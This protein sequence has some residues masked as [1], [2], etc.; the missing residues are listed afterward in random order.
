[1]CRTSQVQKIFMVEVLEIPQAV[2]QQRAD[3]SATELGS[4]PWFHVSAQYAG[5]LSRPDIRDTVVLR[6]CSLWMNHPWETTPAFS[7]FWWPLAFPGL[8]FPSP[9]SSYGFFHEWT[10]VVSAL[11]GYWCQ[12]WSHWSKTHSN[13]LIWLWLILSR[14]Y[15]QIMPNSAVLRTGIWPYFGMVQYKLLVW[16]LRVWFLY[17]FYAGWKTFLWF[18]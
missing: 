5:G 3:W 6:S 2:W 11:W 14:P 4:G 8:W 16:M 13:D 10:H 18:F 1:M 17:C 7:N 9:L 12:H 15:Y